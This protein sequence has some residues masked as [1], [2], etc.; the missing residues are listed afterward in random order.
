MGFK[1]MHSR[2]AAYFAASNK[3]FAYTFPVTLV[4]A[5]SLRSLS[6]SPFWLVPAVIAAIE[7]IAKTCEIWTRKR[8]P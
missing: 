3:T 5:A 2:F 7:A 6:D 1:S 8:T 4:V